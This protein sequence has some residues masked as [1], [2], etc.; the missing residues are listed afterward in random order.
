MDTPVTAAPTP[1]ADRIF[2]LDT[3]RGFAVLGILLMNILGFGLPRPGYTTPT[4][5]VGGNEGLNLWAWFAEMFYFEGTM[6]GLFTVLFGAG[7][8]LYTSRLERAGLGLDMAHYYFR[9]NIWLFIFGLFNAWILL[10]G[11]DILF[12]YGL[13][14]LFLFV[15]CKLP[16]R[17]LLLWAALFMTIQPMVGVKD[18]FAF[19]DAQKQAPALIAM[20]KAD[21]PMTHHPEGDARA[22]S[23][24]VAQH[25]ARSRERW[26]SASSRCAAATPP[27]PRPCTAGCGTR[28]RSTSPARDCG[29]AW[30]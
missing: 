23:R 7:V 8:I 26:P 25:P 30:A 3:I 18:Y 20:E 12:D 14:A 2:A 1:P 11:G 29:N 22:V 16:A 5:L 15:F 9:R 21:K 13:A 17:K 28:R 24:R 27:P 19:T 10:W 6:R 4:A